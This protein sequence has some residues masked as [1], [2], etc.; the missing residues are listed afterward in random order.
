MKKRAWRTSRFTNCHLDPAR[1]FQV[2]PI[3]ESKLGG[4][5]RMR[6]PTQ[7]YT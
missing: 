4:E 2:M 6:R 5:K 3:T 1:K 7:M